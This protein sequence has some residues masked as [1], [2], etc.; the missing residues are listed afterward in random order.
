[1][2][3][4][5]DPV[6]TKMNAVQTQEKQATACLLKL[7]VIACIVAMMATITL[8][9]SV[10]A[11]SASN[12]PQLP[13]FYYGDAS[14]NGDDVPKNAQIRARID[15]TTVGYID[16]ERSGEYGEESTDDKLAIFG[17]KTD[18]GETIEFFLKLTS[19]SGLIKADETATWHTGEIVELDLSFEGEEIE[20]TDPIQN[21]TEEE[22]TT[23]PTT[24]RTTTTARSTSAGNTQTRIPPPIL[25]QGREQQGPNN[26]FSYT[27]MEQDKQYL[28]SLDDLGT[29]LLR[30]QI[31][32][33]QA[34]NDV[35]LVFNEV[36][37]PETL[38]LNTVY[39]Y[40]KIDAPMIGEETVK[41]AIIRFKVDNAWLQENDAAPEDVVLMRY[42]D[43]A[44]LTLETIHEGGDDEENYYRASTPGFSYFAVA[45][46]GTGTNTGDAAATT[47]KK[48]KSSAATGMV[49][50][51][52]KGP[53]AILGGIIVLLLIAVL[54][55]GFYYV[56]RRQ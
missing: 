33:A 28:L 21:D 34:I 9:P 38:P 47:S 52:I 5:T 14:Y 17:E 25:P 49:A 54:A 6:K 12:P 35:E 22:Q 50:T 7:V 37:N 55:L 53:T 32:L 41:T 15:G 30:L 48:Q 43:G 18:E 16:I 10:F 40:L 3:S 11:A 51:I 27:L 24:T 31:V 13:A 46:K 20:D 39:R 23:T 56:R 29:P 19:S 1:M 42:R 8:A 36:D 4:Q 2:S 45:T 44:W 26:R